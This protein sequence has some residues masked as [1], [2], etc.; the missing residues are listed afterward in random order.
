MNIVDHALEN[1]QLLKKIR[2]LRETREYVLDGQYIAS[3]NFADKVPRVLFAA[4][5]HYNGTVIAACA[6]VEAAERAIGVLR[7]VSVEKIDADLAKL[8]EQFNRP[9]IE[10][11]VTGGAA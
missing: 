1:E 11:M 10:A 3:E 8:L 2:E 6:S 4:Q 7:A 5:G 9:L